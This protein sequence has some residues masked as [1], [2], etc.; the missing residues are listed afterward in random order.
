MG[1]GRDLNG[2]GYLAVPASGQGPGVIVL[3]EWWGLVPHIKAVAD[4]FAEAGYVALAPDLYNGESTTAPDEAQRKMM[5][6]NIEATA[7][8]L[9]TS[10]EYLL[11]HEATNTKKIGV[12]G[13][14]MGGQLALLAATVSNNI[15]AAVDFYGIHPN[16]EPDLARLSAPI[17]GFFGGQDSFVPVE[18][19][20]GLVAAI[21]SAGAS[22][23]THLYPDAGHAFFN[24]TR[25]EAYNAEAAEDAW[26]KTLTFFQTHLA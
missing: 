18:S 9:E 16:V 23:E 20:E 3:Q 26:D 4:R 14:C 6:L 7:R 11:N 13:F 8:S 1:M 24:D 17:L 21:K 19:V 22:I 2:L 15:G 12:V 25:P 5:A 10:V